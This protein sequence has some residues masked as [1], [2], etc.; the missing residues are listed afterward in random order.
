MDSL[1]DMTK[2]L[3]LSKTKMYFTYAATFIL[4][5]GTLFYLNIFWSRDLTSYRTYFYA[6]QDTDIIGRLAQVDWLKD[7]GY[8]VLQNISVGLIPFEVFIALI[9]FMSLFIKLLALMQI[10]PRVSILL[11][12]PY[13][14][15]LGFMHE[16]TQLR[17]GLALGFCLW[18]LVFWIQEKRAHAIVALLVGSLFHISI[19]IYFLIFTLLMLATQ[20]GAVVFGVAILVAI[21]LAFP[22]VTSQALLMIGEIT[23]ARYM[24]YSQGII[25]HELNVTGLFQY[26]FLLFALLA[27]IIWR[28]FSPVLQT[29][30]QWRQLALVCAM[31]AI[32][33]L[34]DF[35][36]NTI[37]ASRL[38]DLML[39]PIALSLGLLLE[40]LWAR[41][42][43]K[44]FIFLVVLLSLYCLARGYTI[45]SFR[46]QAPVPTIN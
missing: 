39:L 9:I 14:M 11:A 44:L 35:R 23:N 32:A 15:L 5:W 37:V 4:V 8:F 6:V 34:I 13:L 38:A 25:F 27:A 19:A 17:A 20:F 36:F 18:A 28:Y 2:N 22:M 33:F 12:F 29:A 40:Q 46:P 1:I 24:S 41:K 21:V 45:F 30:K 16:G 43:R 3:E 10:Y 31:V 7:P 42:K 26:Y